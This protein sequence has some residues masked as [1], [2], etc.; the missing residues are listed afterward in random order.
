MGVKFPNKETLE[1]VAHGIGSSMYEGFAPT[2][3]DIK[4]AR[5]L[6]LGILSVHQL[7]KFAKGEPYEK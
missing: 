5:D 4:V 1:Q 6:R 2:Q 7:I 3:E